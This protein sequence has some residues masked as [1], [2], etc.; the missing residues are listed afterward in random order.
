METYAEIYKNK[1]KLK[2]Q[3][4][5]KSNL[6]NKKFS[7]SKSN[8]KNNKINQNNHNK[9][10]NKTYDYIHNNSF[11]IKKENQNI[12]YIPKKYEIST[13][14]LTINKENFINNNIKIDNQNDK[15][16]F[17]D[18]IK[19]QNNNNKKNK[20]Y[21]NNQ[22][23]KNKE[24]L[25]INKEDLVNNFFINK[26]IEENKELKK[27]YEDD[28][29]KE[30]NN[31]FNINIKEKNKRRID[32]NKNEIY[33]VEGEIDKEKKSKII[34]QFI[35]KNINQNKKI[36][37]N[38]NLMKLNK[39]LKIEDI[40]DDD[41]DDNINNENEYINNQNLQYKNYDY[42]NHS[43]NEDFIKNKRRKK[44]GNGNDLNKEIKYYSK[45]EVFHNTDLIFLNNST[46]IKREDLYK[47]TKENFR[48]IVKNILNSISIKINQIE[49]DLIIK[50]IAKKSNYII[51]SQ[52]NELLLELIK[53]IFPEEFKNNKKYITNYFLN[54]LFNCYESLLK[55]KTDQLQT[56]Y[57]YKYNLIMSLISIVPNKNQIL[58]INKIIFTI[59]EIYEKYF[60][61]E[62]NNNPKIIKKSLKNL[63]DFSKDF[64]I[65][66]FIM[67]ETQIITYYK[68]A[69]NYE[70]S[71]YFFD[72]E[73]NKGILFTLN[74]FI[75]F[76]IHLSLYSFIKTYEKISQ[77][78]L[79]NNA[80]DESKLLLLLEK[81]E[82]SLGM[83]NFTRKFLRNSSHKLSFIPSKDIYYLVGEIDPNTGKFK[84]NKIINNLL[85]SHS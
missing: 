11:E 42:D 31:N 22:I 21:F 85:N 10:L 81:L 41:S 7:K 13:N 75:L 82:S 78:I 26:N 51:Y 24:S 23:N 74:H 35:L 1:L 57:N 76:I 12:K 61:Y 49:I 55:E 67:K 66:P 39:K 9:I 79:D 2:K 60:Q 56:F 54:I 53:K 69:I 5:S 43:Y 63:I 29:L 52:F 46:Y 25:N 77:D 6:K 47:M 84:D 65:I 28:Y 30:N 50:K 18:S 16:S 64:E 4:K 70:Q 8:H 44:M 59:I 33:K 27:Y 83:K 40:I 72:K 58:I 34:S 73:I 32:K 37:N 62:F 15:E 80:T 20:H 48:K 3:S 19:A 68:I 17:E 71:Y 36:N 14:N 38:K 45:A